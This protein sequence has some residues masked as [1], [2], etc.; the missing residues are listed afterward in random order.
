[1]EAISKSSGGKSN[2]RLVSVVANDFA[3][4]SLIKQLTVDGV[5]TSGIQVSKCDDHATA[6]YIS[7]HDTKGDLILACADMSLI[8]KDSFAGHVKEQLQRAQPQNIVF[9]CNISAKV[10]DEAL[11]FVNEKLSH[12]NVIIEPTS[13]PKSKRISQMNT[14]SLKVF[15]FNIILLITPT[16]AELKSIYF[17]FRSCGHFDNNHRWRAVLDSIGFD[18][19]FQEKLN[20]IGSKNKILQDALD[21]EYLL[22]SFQLLPFFPNILLKL[23]AR[24]ALYISLSTNINDDSISNSPTSQYG[25]EFFV[26]SRGSLYEGSS[27]RMGIMIQYFPIPSENVDLAVKNVTGAGDSLLGYLLARLLASKNRKNDKLWL[28]SEMEHPKQEQWK[29]E[30]IYKAQIASG[31]SLQSN[32]AVSCKIKN[33]M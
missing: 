24:G 19:K 10:M 4:K 12:A 15:P 5:D 7:M 16:I 6:Q 1:M 28:A 22:Q 14:E 11:E 20:I 8:E 33:L 17:S 2:S 30:S 9:D 21:D 29:W 32:M 27:K 31:L 3:G 23:G 25:P 13:S 26:T 18:S